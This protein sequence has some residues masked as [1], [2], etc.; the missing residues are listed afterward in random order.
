VNSAQ[1]DLPKARGHVAT[2]SENR[3]FKWRLSREPAPRVVAAIPTS[4][5]IEPVTKPAQ[6][7]I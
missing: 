3:S 4:V 2:D 6:P 5:A 1:G 7:T